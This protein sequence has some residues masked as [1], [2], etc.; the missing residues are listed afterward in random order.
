MDQDYYKILEVNK[1]ATKKEMASGLVIT[2]RIL[3][4]SIVFL[5]V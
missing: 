5:R 2:N 1:D 4:K 3:M